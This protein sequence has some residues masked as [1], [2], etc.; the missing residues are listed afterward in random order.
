MAWCTYIQGMTLWYTNKLPSTSS[1]TTFT[2]HSNSRSNSPT[3]VTLCIQYAYL[4]NHCH[5]GWASYCALCWY[6]S[7]K[8][9]KA[10]PCYSWEGLTKFFLFET[11]Y[12]ILLNIHKIQPNQRRQRC[13]PHF[14]RQEKNKS[15][16]SPGPSPNPNPISNPF[17]WPFGQR[18]ASDD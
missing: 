12:V 17:P 6:K 2:P 16:T 18:A 7:D 3:Y 4:Q 13:L 8:A 5:V 9:G 10:V 11:V 15:I 1:Y 14:V